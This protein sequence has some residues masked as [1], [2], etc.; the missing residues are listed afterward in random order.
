MGRW[1]TGRRPWRKHD[2]PCPPSPPRSGS[3]GARC[4]PTKTTAGWSGTWC[5]KGG[6]TGSLRAQPAPAAKT[7][8]ITTVKLYTGTIKRVEATETWP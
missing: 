4:D 5:W 6:G 2:P 1:H 7:G 3:Q 8:L